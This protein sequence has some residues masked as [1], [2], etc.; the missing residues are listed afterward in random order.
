MPLRASNVKRAEPTITARSLLDMKLHRCFRRSS[1]VLSLWYTSVMDLFGTGFG[2]RTSGNCFSTQASI[3]PFHHR[4][5]HKRKH[6]AK[7][8]IRYV[9]FSIG[10]VW[11]PF[12][13]FCWDINDIK[14][15]QH[16][17]I[18]EFHNTVRSFLWF[19][20]PDIDQSDHHFST[21]RASRIPHEIPL[22]YVESP[23][24]IRP[25]VGPMRHS[26]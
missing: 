19:I 8:L 16:S 5:V 23:L 3:S 6:L 22:L 11:W 15:Q 25:S 1:T 9:C 17:Q 2:F 12:S 10:R 20:H 14:E 18:P 24:K 21:T 26:E 13:S 7:S 4:F